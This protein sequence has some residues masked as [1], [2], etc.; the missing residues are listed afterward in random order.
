MAL[1]KEDCTPSELNNFN[2]IKKF[3]ELRSKNKDFPATSLM[4]YLNFGHLIQQKETVYDLLSYGFS[5]IYHKLP[6]LDAIHVTNLSFKVNH[7]KAKEHFDLLMLKFAHVDYK[8]F[9]Q[10]YEDML[11]QVDQVTT[12]N[13]V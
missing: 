5:V 10:P 7:P 2:S 8:T 1:M 3:Y 6:W 12:Q 13:M 11:G 4:P 9:L